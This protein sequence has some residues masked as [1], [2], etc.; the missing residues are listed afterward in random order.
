MRNCQTLGWAQELAKF[1]SI[2]QH[3]AFLK[4]RG[5]SHCVRSLFP[6]VR[7][8]LHAVRQFHLS[9]RGDAGGPGAL[10]SLAPPRKQ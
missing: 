4:T 5:G 2:A 1:E 7:G 8:C 3:I 9:E 10:A 6:S